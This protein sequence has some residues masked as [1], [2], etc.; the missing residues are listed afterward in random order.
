MFVKG[1]LVGL[2]ELDIKV[3]EILKKFNI[4]INEIII[5]KKVIEKLNKV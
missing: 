3:L 5:D 1:N 4:I 2:Y